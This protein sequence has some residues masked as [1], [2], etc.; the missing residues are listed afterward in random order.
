MIYSLAEEKSMR[1]K[2]VH[3]LVFIPSIKV[4]KCGESVNSVKVSDH[5][6]ADGL[7]MSIDVMTNIYFI[8]VG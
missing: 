2:R 3:V 1:S 6:Y 8:V 7:T 5:R 4:Q